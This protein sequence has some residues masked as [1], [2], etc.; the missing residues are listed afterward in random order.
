[1]YYNYESEASSNRFLQ[2]YLQDY[3]DRCDGLGL[4]NFVS[5]LNFRI[6][7]LHSNSQRGQEEYSKLSLTDIYQQSSKH[8]FLLNLCVIFSL[9]VSVGDLLQYGSS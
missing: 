5:P 6:L 3:P 9:L 1:M 2:L 8:S 4:D 7:P